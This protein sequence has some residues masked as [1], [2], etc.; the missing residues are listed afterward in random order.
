MSA[1]KSDFFCRKIYII[2]I[3]NFCLNFSVF[4]KSKHNTSLPVIK[5]QKID[6][7]TLRI[8]NI[9]NS[10]DYDKRPGRKTS[11]EKILFN[12]VMFGLVHF[13]AAVILDCPSSH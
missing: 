2:Y 12:V 7:D 3:C 10:H 5:R 13:A 6:N 8:K 9:F 1:F 11:G 4:I